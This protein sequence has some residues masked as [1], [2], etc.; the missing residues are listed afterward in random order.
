MGQSSKISTPRSALSGTAS[1][2]LDFSAVFFEDDTLR[3]VLDRATQYVS[4]GVCVHL[5]GTAGVGKTSLALRIARELGRPIALMAGNEW[6]TSADFLGREVGST[7]STVVDR[8]VHSVRRTE[9]KSVND[10]QGSIL[11]KAM[12]QGQTLIYDEFTRASPEANA[13]LLS[14][15]EEGVLV[16]T[17]G[18]NPKPFLRA[19]SEFRII[20][21]SNPHDYIGVNSAPDALVDRVVTIPI[22]EPGIDTMAGIVA[23]R[24]GL[25][26][27]LSQRIAGLVAHF[28]SDQV[29]NRVSATRSAIL[30]ARI[31]AAKVALGTLSEDELTVIATD[32]LV[33]RGISAS[34][35]QIAAALQPKKAA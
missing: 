30:I 14:V 16:S 29:S 33:G 15:L 1:A 28:R 26:F 3:A 10:W 23:Q 35:Q 12:E 20:M 6:L 8:Y 9:K 11:A 18:N 2:A 7:T 31:A 4:A 13:T 19:H 34:S 22:K 25:A 5:T 24:T 27:D 21:T 32:V 17:D